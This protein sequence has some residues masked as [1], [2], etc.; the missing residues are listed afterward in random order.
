[1]NSITKTQADLQAMCPFLGG[2]SWEEQ[3]LALWEGDPVGNPTEALWVW[4]GILIDMFYL[5]RIGIMPLVSMMVCLRPGSERGRFP[6]HHPSLWLTWEI[7][8]SLLHNFCLWWSRVPSSQR[9][10]MLCWEAMVGDATQ[11][12]PNA[13]SHF[14]LLI[15]VVQESKKAVIEALKCYWS[16]LSGGK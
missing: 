15:P 11:I 10:I 7:L 1:M 9:R 12:N 13:I 3:Q 16:W 8:A 4:I 6:V 2:R 5:E 14:V